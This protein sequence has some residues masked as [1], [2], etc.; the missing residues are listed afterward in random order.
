MTVRQVGWKAAALAAGGLL[1]V[2]AMAH[3]SG[4]ALYPGT[5][6]AG[7]AGAFRGVADDWSAA[8]WNPAGL[9]D[10]SGTQI[11]GTG[12]FVLPNMN[13]TPTEFNGYTTSTVYQN[14]DVITAPGI[15]GFMRSGDK[16][17][18]YG[19]GVWA[20]FG[21]GFRWDGLYALPPGY[22]PSVTYPTQATE[23]DLKV[24]DI[25]PTVAYRL[26]P[27]LSVGAGVSMNYASLML[28]EAAL[29]QNPL[30]ETALSPL[31]N[32]PFDYLPVD[33]NVKGTGFGFGANGGALWKASEK[34]KVGASVRWYTDLDING[35]GTL[36]A[37]FPQSASMQA[38][39]ASAL[40]GQLQKIRGAVAAGLPGYAEL[41]TK[42][43]GDSARAVGYFAGGVVPSQYSAAAKIPLPLNVGLGFGY[44]VTPKWLVSADLDFTR[45]S[46]L[47]E[48]T[49][50]LR[51]STTTPSVLGDSLDDNLKFHWKNVTRISVGTR[52]DAG[53]IKGV[54]T[55]LL[56]GFY[57]D[58]TAAPNETLVPIIPDGN[59]RHIFQGGAVLSHKHWS[60]T[61]VYKFITTSD[62]VVSAYSFDTTGLDPAAVQ[63]FHLLGSP[64]N[65]AGTY[66]L[67]I[68][69]WITGLQYSF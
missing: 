35:D 56:G 40:H 28:H 60:L 63:Q 11:V 32:A 67:R 25:H 59:T 9:V 1:S 13:L 55:R 61:G 2:A 30:S 7:M 45:H 38:D 39:L 47:D 18:A 27:T 51:N 54:Q 21:L 5:A 29:N 20:P 53:T 36:T 44:Q 23:S 33:V 43:L 68:H 16:K 62:R 26:S 65:V 15:N 31:I 37:Y 6:A 34:L 4:L 12:T 22:N 50:Q 57:S 58:P 8:F 49:L 69:E 46:T 3:A 24:V 48:V 66:H 64:T 42:T 14:R 52:Y 10:L 19:I 17:L 41:L